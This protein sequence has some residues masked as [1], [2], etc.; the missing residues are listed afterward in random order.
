MHIVYCTSQL[1]PRPTVETLSR[2]KKTEMIL[3]WDWKLTNILVSTTGQLTMLTVKQL[4]ESSYWLSLEL[5]ATKAAISQCQIWG[6]IDL[7]PGSPRSDL[8]AAFTSI[9]WQCSEDPMAAWANGCFMSNPKWALQFLVCVKF[10]KMG[11]LFLCSILPKFKMV[12]L[13]HSKM[14]SGRCM[15]S[16]WV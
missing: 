11:S 9:R 12:S 13:W 15:P 14:G 4:P 3:Q 6:P 16:N 5:T 10:S 2:G 8:N 1:P 7:T